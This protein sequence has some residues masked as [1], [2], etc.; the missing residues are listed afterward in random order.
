MSKAHLVDRIAALQAAFL[1]E[2]GGARLELAALLS[3]TLDS[4]RRDRLIALTHSIAGRAGTFGF[5][6]LSAAAADLH[7]RI[8]TGRDTREAARN[9]VNAVAIVLDPPPRA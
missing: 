1:K 4:A 9:L 3:Q 7:D 5:P 6:E 8:E 2:L